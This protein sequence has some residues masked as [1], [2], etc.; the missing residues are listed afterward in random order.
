MALN[1][2]E[3][4]FVLDTIAASAAGVSVVGGSVFI[5]GADPI[6]AYKVQGVPQYFGSAVGRPAEY[7]ITSTAAIAAATT[8]SGVMQQV[9]AGETINFP[10]SYTT[11]AAAPSAANL[12]LAIEA[13][14]QA[15]IDGGAVFGTVDSTGSGVTFTG[16]VAA[17]VIAFASSTLTSAQTASTITATVITNVDTGRIMTATGHGLT[18]GTVYNITMSGLAGAG[19]PSLNGRTYP[20]IPTTAD[21]ITII[22]TSDTGAITNG[23]YVLNVNNNAFNKFYSE[24]GRIT[25]YDV[26]KPYVGL[27]VAQVSEADVESGVVIPEVILVN[28]TVATNSVANLAAFFGA[29][30][31]GL[32]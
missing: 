20:C 12:Y 13:V 1:L 25:G 5:T 15:G 27:Q 16:S 26:T 19:A 6:N 11:G 2:N 23:T 8:Y 3:R 10:F 18:V 7:L 29:I 17:P 31:V 28:A 32:A 24:A 30:N 4:V 9:L 22:G 14:I 21:S